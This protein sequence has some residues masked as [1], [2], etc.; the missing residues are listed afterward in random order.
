LNPNGTGRMVMSYN[1]DGVRSFTWE[2]DSDDEELSIISEVPEGMQYEMT[3]IYLTL[4]LRMVNGRVAF[5]HYTPGP[6]FLY[7]KQ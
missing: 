4:G 7:I 3:P 5:E 6:T 1:F 2:Y